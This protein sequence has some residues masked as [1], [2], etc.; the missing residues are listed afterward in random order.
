MIRRFILSLLAAAAVSGCDPRLVHTSNLSPREVQSLSGTWQGEAKLAFGNDTCPG[1]FR[2]TL[3]V[4]QGLAEGTLIDEKTPNAPPTVFKTF[5]DYDGTLN[6]ATRLSGHDSNVRGAFNRD[7]F[8][9]EAMGVHC[10]YLI[11]LR[12]T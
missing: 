7:S 11:R 12:R 10:R 1:V 6:A 9:G 3:K 5:V 4:A 8:T 2:W